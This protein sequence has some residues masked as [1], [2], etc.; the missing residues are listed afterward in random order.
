MLLLCER[1]RLCAVFIEF[2]STLDDFRVLF[3][4]NT[5]THA[6]A[7]V[8]CSARHIVRISFAFKILTLGA[9]FE[10][11]SLMK[12]SSVY[13]SFST[14]RY[15]NE[16]RRIRRLGNE[17]RKSY[18]SLIQPDWEYFDEKVFFLFWKSVIEC[19]LCRKW[20]DLAV[21][22]IRYGYGRWL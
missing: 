18:F 10:I 2:S 14:K 4:F 20:R 13:F 8:V 9:R 7:W 5:R 3:T 12:W 19:A 21:S 1:H 16:C 6:N 22:S 11:D 15:S 17:H